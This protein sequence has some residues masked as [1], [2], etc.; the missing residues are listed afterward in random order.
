MLKSRV[1]TS[2]FRLEPEALATLATEGTL[3]I[4]G[5]DDLPGTCQVLVPLV[6][7]IWLGHCVVV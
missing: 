7:L 3:P 6:P 2:H 4:Q 1:R 5:V